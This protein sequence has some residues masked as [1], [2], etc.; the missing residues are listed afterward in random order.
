MENGGENMD[1][2]EIGFMIKSFR[3]RN[4]IKQAELAEKLGVTISALSKIESGKQRVDTA[5]FIA[6]LNMSK[7]YD[8][9]F[10]I[11]M[12]ADANQVQISNVRAKDGLFQDLITFCREYPRI[13]LEEVS[14]HEAGHMI[15]HELPIK[16]LE[17]ANLNPDEYKAYGSVGHGSWTKT[18][19]VAFLNKSVTDSAQKGIYVALL[20]RGD[21]EGFYLSLCQGYSYFQEKYGSE[22]KDNIKKV[23]DYLKKELRTIDEKMNVE[24]IDLGTEAN[25]A[26][27]YESA[28]IIGKYYY[29][30]QDIDEES[31]IS[32]FKSLMLTY[33]EVCGLM[34][35]KSYD[36]FIE[37]ILKFQSLDYA[38]EIE[39]KNFLESLYIDTNVIMDRP[40][41]VTEIDGKRMIFEI[42]T[43]K[44]RP[45]RNRAVALHAMETANYKCECN[46]EHE[47]FITK[48]GKP[49]F[50]IHHLI[51]MSEQGN[52]QGWLD[53]LDNIVVLCPNCHKALEMGSDETK[54]AMLR[55]L[56]YS[57]IEKLENKGIE[58]TFS[59]L[60][61][62]YGI[63]D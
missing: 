12:D 15:R 63:N 14:K 22:A 18:P 52:F 35:D 5:T 43:H 61:K 31:F 42:K 23:A 37:S 54:E 27:S 49:F 33:R 32:D 2:I 19:W 56:F 3:E 24:E 48:K 51:P 39:Q 44:V 53:N 36:A 28:H 59:K 10:N 40:D 17:K 1:V 46:P 11:D 57:R 4:N 38:A 62:I 6:Y 26:S 25:L 34:K 58:L 21:G 9:F 30:S 20:F 60:K 50:E 7:E 13:T 41:I 16:L 29:V 55:K 45:V 8:K 47:T